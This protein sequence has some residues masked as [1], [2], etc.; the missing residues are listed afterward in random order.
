MLN[1]VTKDDIITSHL[2]HNTYVTIAFPGEENGYTCDSWT[3]HQPPPAYDE[4]AL[5]GQIEIFI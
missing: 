2:A 1:R 5:P 4:V 3:A